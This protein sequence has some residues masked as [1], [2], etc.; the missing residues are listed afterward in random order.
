MDKILIDAD[1]VR[2]FVNPPRNDKCAIYLEAVKRAYGDMSRRT[3]HFGSEKYKGQSKK[4]EES[5]QVLR[6]KIVDLLLK[7]ESKLF[8]FRSSRSFNIWHKKMC[9]K[10]SDIFT[11]CDESGVVPINATP[12]GETD[13]SV[14]NSTFSMGQAQK[15][16]NMVWKYVFVFYQYFNALN[17]TDYVS[18]LDSFKRIIPL[19]HAPIDSKVIEAATSVG[20][21]YSLK[22][23]KPKWP[24]SQLNYCEYKKFQNDIRN[25]LKKKGQCPFLWELENFPFE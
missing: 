16:V 12:E 20:R 10:V 9:K 21:D 6:D 5:R 23:T 7:E 25:K 13:P 17:E 2:F 22:C 4:A 19:L 3:L 8:A 14:R 24:W 18:E 1:S 11:T 15:V